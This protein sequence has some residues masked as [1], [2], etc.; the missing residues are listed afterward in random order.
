MGGRGNLKEGGRSSK[1][2]R[3]QGDGGTVDRPTG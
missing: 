2:K 1:G 3:E